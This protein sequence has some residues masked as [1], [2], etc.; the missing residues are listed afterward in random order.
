MDKAN[1]RKFFNLFWPGI[2]LVIAIYVGLTIF[3]DLRDNFAVELWTELGYLNT[4][5]ILVIAEIPTAIFVLVVIGS[6][7]LLKNN[8]KAFYLSLTLCVIAGIGFL[9]STYLFSN[10]AINPIFW[11]ILM[12]FLMYMPYLI[13]HTILFERWIAFFKYKGNLG[14]LMYMS[15]SIGY[16]GSVLV[17]LYKNYG[18][19]GFNWLP[20][21]TN[22]TWIIG[23]LITL[24][25][26]LALLYFRKKEKVIL[27]I[28]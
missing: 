24:L 18:I 27:T 17:L 6:M 10:G 21:F 19:K 4:P 20:F 3:R 5:W 14:Y 11:M 12:G 15:D 25:G 7:I 16:F 26:I 9:I 22:T 28:N 8:K 23:M 1:R 13:F 2:L